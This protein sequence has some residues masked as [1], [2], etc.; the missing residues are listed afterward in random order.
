M[1]NPCDLQTI[2]KAL[3][4]V[5]SVLILCSCDGKQ[6]QEVAQKTEDFLSKFDPKL[7]TVRDS[8]IAEIAAVNENIKTVENLKRGF[9]QGSA[10]EIA[11]TKIDQ[12]KNQ[13]NELTAR[14][15]RVDE[16]AQKGVMLRELNQ[17]DGGGTVSLTSRELIEEAERTLAESRKMT[18]TLES[19]FGGSVRQS[20]TKTL[21][22]APQTVPQ[23]STSDAVPKS[24]QFTEQLYRVCNIAPG[25]YL[26]IRSRPQLNGDIVARIPVT[27][28][29]IEVVGEA[30]NADTVQWAPIHYG[31]LSGFVNSNNLM[32][33]ESPVSA[34][35]SPGKPSDSIQKAITLYPDLQVKDSPMNRE[36]LRNYNSRKAAGDKTL[37]KQDWPLIIAKEAAALIERQKS[38]QF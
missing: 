14:L 35:I 32:L 26:S 13:K 27:A 10:K 18:R 20:N 9:N 25:S 17:I 11:Q 15:S 28:T 29:G 34:Q 23:P 4:V 22:M 16:E 21:P 3:C 36:F 2:G 8:L 30:V 33:A 31:R 6:K 19:E 7:K 1:A 5:S 12:L 38:R 37:L 24:T